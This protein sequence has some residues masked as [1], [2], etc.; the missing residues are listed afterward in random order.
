IVE[1]HM[2]TGHIG[3]E[4][5]QAVVDRWMEKANVK[6]LKKYERQVILNIA[7]EWGPDSEVWRDQYE[8]AID[9][10]RAAG[11]KNMLIIDSGGGSAGPGQNAH[12]L[13]TGGKELIDHD[14]Q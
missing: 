3:P 5:L 11:I 7:N 4:F 14:P 6:W 13:A 8:I 10:L 12:T 9:R 1:D 2:A